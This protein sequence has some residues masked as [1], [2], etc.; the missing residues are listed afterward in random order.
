MRRA[1]REWE[2][3]WKAKAGKDE[4]EEEEEEEE[5]L[6]RRGQRSGVGR[7]GCR[8]GRSLWTALAL[9]GKAVERSMIIWL[10]GRTIL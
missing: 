5:D 3:G 7:G 2:E 9:A 1:W 8:C 4:E 10:E 6:L